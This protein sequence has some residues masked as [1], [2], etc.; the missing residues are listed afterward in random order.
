MT[1]RRR[2]FLVPGAFFSAFFLRCLV[3]CRNQHLR[4]ESIGWTFGQWSRTVDPVRCLHVILIK[5]AQLL[6]DSPTNILN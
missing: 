2:P 4:Q 5:Y 1:L 6:Q 3:G